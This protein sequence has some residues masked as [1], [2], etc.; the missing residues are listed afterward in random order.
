MAPRITTWAR[1]SLRGRPGDMDRW[2][3]EESRRERWAIVGAWG[4]RS[5]T[6]RTYRALGRQ[7]YPPPIQYRCD[8]LAG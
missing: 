5:V 4:H 7:Y 3:L 6:I 2:G 8:A 1:L